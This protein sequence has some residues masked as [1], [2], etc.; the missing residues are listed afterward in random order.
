MIYFYDYIVVLNVLLY[1][2]RMYESHADCQ[3]ETG[4]SM[5]FYQVTGG[6]CLPYLNGSY[7]SSP[8]CGG[9]HARMIVFVS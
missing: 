8:S 5:Y 1:T 9:K 3:S 7:A 6:H 2:P 4:M